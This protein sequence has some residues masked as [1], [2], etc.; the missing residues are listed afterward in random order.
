MFLMVACVADLHSP[1][2]I[3]LFWLP[4]KGKHLHAQTNL[5]APPSGQTC[6][7]TSNSVS[8]ITVLLTAGVSKGIDSLADAKVSYHSRV[9]KDN[10]VSRLLSGPDGEKPNK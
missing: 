4:I 3:N 9:W 6:S 7:I 8:F 1:W 10:L 5:N 2:V